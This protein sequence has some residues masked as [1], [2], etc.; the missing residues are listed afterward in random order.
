VLHFVTC[1]LHC[2]CVYLI[3]FLVKM[4]RRIGPQDS[5]RVQLIIHGAVQALTRAVMMIYAYLMTEYPL[6]M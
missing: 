3:I 5:T 1:N 4:L 2:Y 6:M